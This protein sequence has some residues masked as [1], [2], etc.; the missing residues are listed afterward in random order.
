MTNTK[1][2]VKDDVERLMATKNQLQGEIDDSE[3]KFSSART[4]REKHLQDLTAKIDQ[5]E[6]KAAQV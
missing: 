3:S 4:D 1:N 2:A 6:K 5:L